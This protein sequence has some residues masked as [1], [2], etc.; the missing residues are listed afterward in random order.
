[1]SDAVADPASVAPRRGVGLLDGLILVV[2]ALAVWQGLG[3]YTQGVTITTPLGTLSYLGRLALTGSFWGH[4][5]ATLAAFLYAFLISAS[6]GLMLGLVF[7]VRRFAGDVAEPILAGFYTIPKITLY[8]V[9]LLIFGLG[10][11][12]KVAFGVMHGLVPIVLFTTAAI[13]GMP[14]ILLRAARS[15][16]L[17]NWDT[18]QHVILPAVLPSIVNG[19]RV[20]FSLSLL[21]VL[22]GEMFSS[23]RGLGFLLMNSLS[24]HNVP[25]TTAVTVLVIV[26]AIV[27]NMLML[28]LVRLLGHRA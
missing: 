20:G 3:I 13:R 21:G 15:L 22:I 28:R 8:P 7:G 27:A 24:M 12:A 6:A 25:M 1:M 18:A 16:R 2:I 9:V 19:L 14:P 17:S 10:V 4:V 11:S 23:Q 26:F 5:S